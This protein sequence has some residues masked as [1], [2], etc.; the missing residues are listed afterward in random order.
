MCIRDR[1]RDDAALMI[2]QNA[3]TMGVREG[4]TRSIRSFHAP[5]KHFYGC[6]GSSWVYARWHCD[7]ITDTVVTFT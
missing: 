3:E 6:D 4:K 1:H 2:V 5:R 7:D